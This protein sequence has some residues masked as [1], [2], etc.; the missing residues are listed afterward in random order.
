MYVVERDEIIYTVYTDNIRTLQSIVNVFKKLFQRRDDSAT[1]INRTLQGYG[2]IVP[3]PHPELITVFPDKTE[4]TPGITTWPGLFHFQTT[5][6]D[7]AEIS[8]YSKREHGRVT[9]EIVISYEY[10]RNDELLTGSL[11]LDDPD[12]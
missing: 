8:A 11:T 10:V 7:S 4:I 2:K 1:D 3:S 9:A 5:T 6:L 12:N